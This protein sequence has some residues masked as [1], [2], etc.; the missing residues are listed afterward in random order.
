MN[1]EEYR[2]YCVSKAAVTEHFPFDQ[3]TLVFKVAGKMFALC[4]VEDFD[5]INLK[6]D[7]ERAVELREKFEGIKPGY[8]M[9][10]IHWNT[11]AT[12]GSVSDK[13]I[14]ELIDHSYDLIVTSLP[15]KTR[16][17]FSL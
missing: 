8:H 5:G 1:I 7:P 13:L 15:K 2:D 11:V 9:S 6:C 12:D 10:K 4:D 16:V 14:R 17:E 3:R